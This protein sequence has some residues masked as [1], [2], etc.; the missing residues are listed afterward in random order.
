MPIMK[1]DTMK[2]NV[3]VVFAHPNHDSLNY[4]LL[5]QTK[6]G[7][8]DAGHDVEVLDLYAENFDPV[9]TFDKEH[10]RRELHCRPET[11]Q[12][13]Q[14]VRW[15]DHLVFIFPI[16]WGGM[17]AILKGYFDKVFTSGFSYHF[18]WVIPKGHLKNKTA[19]I[20]T[21]DDTPALFQNF[22]MQD[23]GRVLK[24][25]ICGLV[26]GMRAK[27]H[28]KF[29]YVRGRNPKTIQQWLKRCYR[30]GYFGL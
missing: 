2:K 17:P 15:A 6:A 28:L 30:L 11:E 19:W 22:F 14:Q 9:L 12:Y 8:A 21:T 7:L 1:E 13:R 3:L 23:Y 4:A 26:T 5:E 25:Q 24:K 10:R 29:T 16:W 18:K 27:K 20:I